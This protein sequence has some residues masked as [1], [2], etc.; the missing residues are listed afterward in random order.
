MITWYVKILCWSVNNMLSHIEILDILP[1]LY[2][3]L[4][5][6]YIFRAK[7]IFKSKKIA[8]DENIEFIEN[9]YI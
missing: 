9:F 3:D 4:D 1:S 5:H 2:W 7:E 6:L 8:K